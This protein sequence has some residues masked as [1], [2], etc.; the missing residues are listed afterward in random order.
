MVAPLSSLRKN[1]DDAYPIAHPIASQPMTDQ[2]L[3][4]R[5]FFASGAALAVA[6]ALGATP[7]ADAA[8][9]AEHAPDLDDFLR[10]SALLTGF[11]V[12]ALDRSLAQTYLGAV[13]G[14][15]GSD[16]VEKFYVQAGFRSSTPPATFDEL[17]RTSAFNEE[18]SQVLAEA[19]MTCWYSGTIAALNALH[20]RV[21]TYNDALAWKSVTWTTPNMECRG[22]L[23]AW[24]ELPANGRL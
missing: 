20:L 11:P 14:T 9:S 21:V 12:S 13:N 16:L 10:V 23:G 5:E 22:A 24:S 15:H 8:A 6:G 7:N 17:A 4:R 2:P 19:I 18:S 3:D 1:T